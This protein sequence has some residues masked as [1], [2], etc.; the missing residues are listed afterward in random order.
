MNSFAYI[1]IVA[2][3]CYLFLLMA[4]LAAKRTKVT[5][6]FVYMLVC[7]VLWTGGSFAMRRLYWPSPQLWYHVSICGLILLAYA[8]FIFVRDFS[9]TKPRKLDLLWLV[10]LSVVAVANIFTGWFLAAPEII[11]EQGEPVFVYNTSYGFLALAAILLVVISRMVIIIAHFS[12][13]DEVKRRAFTPVFAGLVALVAGHLALM[14]PK[15]SGFPIDIVSSVVFVACLFYALYR[16]RLFKLTLLVSKGV[17]YLATAI[18]SLAIFLNLVRPL[19]TFIESHIPFVGDND[20]IFIAI[21]FSFITV[22]IYTAMKRFVDKVFIKEEIA[23]AQVL[24]AFSASVAKSL[25]F[26]EIMEE[27][28][29]VIKRTLPVRKVYVCVESNDGSCYQ[30]AHSENPL[31]DCRLRL[32]ADNPIIETLRESGEC[33]FM[34]EFRCLS[35][36]KSMWDEEKREISNLGIECIVPLCDDGALV[37]MVLLTEKERSANY[38]YDDI[39]F[40]TSVGSIGSIAVKN[41]RLYERARLEACTDELTG[42]LNR[43]YFLDTL[44]REFEGRKEHSLALIILNLDDFKL[45][46]QLYGNREGDILICK[47]ADILR[48][49]VGGNGHVARYS[50][51]EFAIILPD[52]D[53]YGAKSMAEIIRSQVADINRENPVLALKPVTMSGGICAIPYGASSPK[54]L[55]ENA[56]MAVYQVKRSGKNAIRLSTGGTSPGELVPPK[57]AH[58]SDVYSEYASTIYALTA[59]I[60]TKDH[61]TFSH[62]KNVAYY[63]S[64]LAYACNMNEDMVEIVREASLLHDIGKIGINEQILNKPDRLSDAE[65]QSM[66]NHVEN[67]VGIIKH[68]P[69]LDY[70]IPAVIGHHE[71]YDGRGYP[72]GLVGEDIPILARI[73]CI[74]DSFDAMV[75][76]RPYK[77]PYPVEHALR[78]IEAQS[79]LQFDPKLA[80]LFVRLV[81]DGKITPILTDVELKI[82]NK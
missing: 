44:Q 32:D 10:L 59:A 1:P 11:M 53:L 71:R 48:A 42:L 74:A 34:E 52:Y 36:Y 60:D 69:S 4:F 26:S 19:R 81:R 22:M 14:I 77:R 27:I 66:K 67:S 2:L 9:S 58:R 17:C 72:R 16:R 76:H 24:H 50:G 21:L 80:P 49:T 39:S 54:E 18:L 29:A 75:S 28:V 5:N 47:V 51:K 30:I 12:R 43:K 13:R 20:V 62:S 7:C 64:E 56:D 65:Y 38:T 15:L 46:N 3:C 73:L 45:Y 6:D 35:A 25:E 57:E 78:E 61:Y 79:G 23:R 31:D 82:V 63:A 33:L 41:A 40:L 37:G 8:F 68:L 70:V 55:V